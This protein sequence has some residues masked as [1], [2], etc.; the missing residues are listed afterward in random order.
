MNFDKLENTLKSKLKKDLP[1][2]KAQNKMLA[3]GREKLS[4]LFKKGVVKKSAVLILLYK[5]NEEIYIVFIK[6]AEDGG[7]HSGQIAFPGGKIEDKD[8]STE[9]A[10]LRETEEEI[11][12][13][14]KNIHVLGKLTPLFIPVS[15][16]DVQPIV[17]FLQTVPNFIRNKDEVAEIYSVNLNEIINAKIV[18]KTFKVRGTEI[19]APF[20]IIG[21]IEI[22]GATAMMLSEFIEIL[23]NTNGKK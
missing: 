19:F 8:K 4:N 5:K 13:S 14:K 12:I 3:T 20:Y 16:Y 22:W 11:G 7:S 17:G 2:F 23:L 21:N 1:G 18:N 15:N 6:R 10:A 9:E